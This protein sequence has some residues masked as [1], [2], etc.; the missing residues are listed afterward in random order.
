MYD[1]L[2]D[3]FDANG[4]MIQLKQINITKGRVTKH[5]QVE[6][7]ETTKRPT[8]PEQRGENIPGMNHALLHYH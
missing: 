1:L 2:Y 3:K 8:L 5:I 4:I 7:T 6:K